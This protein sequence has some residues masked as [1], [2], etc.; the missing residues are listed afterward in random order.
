VVWE[1]LLTPIKR[2][3]AIFLSF[4]NKK[5][6]ISFSMKKITKFLIVILKTQKLFE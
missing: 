5:I 2:Q 3:N 6:N 1:V 4:F